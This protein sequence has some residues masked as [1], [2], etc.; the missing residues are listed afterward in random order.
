M[1]YRSRKKGSSELSNHNE[2]MTMIK[3]VSSREYR[4]QN[5]DVNN[6]GDAPDDDESRL[7]ANKTTEGSRTNVAALNDI[8]KTT[9]T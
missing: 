9:T 8:K 1:H 3:V 6:N 5:K 2:M 4:G 7:V